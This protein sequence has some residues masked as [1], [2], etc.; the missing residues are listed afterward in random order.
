[1]NWD[2][3][4][5]DDDEMMWMFDV[6]EAG[7]GYVMQNDALRMSDALELLGVHHMMSTHGLL[8]VKRVGSVEY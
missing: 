6:N 2:W 3:G 4:A 5:P 1:M 7:A 8:E